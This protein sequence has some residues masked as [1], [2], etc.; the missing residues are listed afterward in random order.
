MISIAGDTSSS[1]AVL[2]GHSLGGYLSLC[3]AIKY[4]E[5]VN[6]L[7]L[8]STGPGFRDEPSRERWNRYVDSMDLGARADP[9]ARLL[10]LQSD[11][12]VIANLASIECPALVVVGGADQRFLLA[13]DY[14][15]AKMP[16]A[17][18]VII[19]GGGHSIHRS[20][21]HEVNRAIQHFLE[22]ARLGLMDSESPTASL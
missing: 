7:V 13:K 12:S 21:S 1:P 18:A 5:L 19:D 4:P 17:T 10:G 9:A 14:M 3:V 8:V 11:S 6:G 20:R 22:N 16:R 15:V 2:V